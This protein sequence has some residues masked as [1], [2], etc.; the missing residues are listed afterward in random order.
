M[1]MLAIEEIEPIEVQALGRQATLGE[2]AEINNNY[3]TGHG[4]TTNTKQ[5]SCSGNQFEM[6]FDSKWEKNKISGGQKLM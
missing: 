3:K 1:K 6:A 4:A 2:I 5:G